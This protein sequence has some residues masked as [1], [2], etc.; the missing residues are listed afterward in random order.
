MLMKQVKGLLV[1]KRNLTRDKDGD[2]DK[3]RKEKTLQVVIRNS[4]NKKKDNE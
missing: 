2:I 4:V 1:V 3:A